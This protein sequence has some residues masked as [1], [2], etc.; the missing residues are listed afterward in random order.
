MKRFIQIICVFLCSAILL[1]GC[2]FTL[3]SGSV[4]NGYTV[5]NWQLSGGTTITGIENIST[6]GLKVSFTKEQDEQD[7]VLT[8]QVGI[9]IEKKHYVN[10]SLSSTYPLC[11]Q[12]AC[13][14]LN[15]GN[16][17]DELQLNGT[18]LVQPTQSSYTLLIN[19]FSDE[20]K[21]L[22]QLTVCP[23]FGTE[24]GSGQLSI[25]KA[26]VDETFTSNS[27]VVVMQKVE[28]VPD[29]SGN[30]DN[31]GNNGNNGNNGGGEGFKI[32][33]TYG[34][35]TISISLSVMQSVRKISTSI[36]VRLTST[37]TVLLVKTK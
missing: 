13:V 16:A 28:K 11:I 27:A 17:T 20:H 3:G 35:S 6:D 36:R 9:S 1:C 4:S 8:S 10:L 22:K 14:L 26:V 18:I 24:S 15:V 31:S 29:D 37:S 19:G 25:H 12:V 7:G 2:N 21:I 32:L 33:P 34:K 5:K 30:N 23:S